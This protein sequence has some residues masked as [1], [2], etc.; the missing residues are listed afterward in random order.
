MLK[1]TSDQVTE[2][3]AASAEP[4]SLAIAK[5]H[6]NITFSDKD[7]EITLQIQ[8][9]RAWVEEYLQ[10]SLVQ[11]TYRADIAG[12]ND[13]ISLPNGPVIAISSI[14]YWDTASPS[15]QQMLSTNIYDLYG[16]QVVRQYG[17]TWPASAT[18]P[19]AVSIT[20]TAGY[21][22]TSSPQVLAEN[23]PAAIRQS[24]LLLVAEMSENKEAGFVGA[25][26]SA[27]PTLKMLLQPW[28]NYR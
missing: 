7:D 14:Q 28:R 1:V 13:A 27:N 17:Q 9:A 22:S 21:A 12:F 11:R 2:T 15:A 24:I 26:Y 25:I 23:V 8:A 4:V 6:L 10:R 3:T 16:S 20:Y 5:E 19:D 18:R